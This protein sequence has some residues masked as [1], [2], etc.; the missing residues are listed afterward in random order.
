[1]ALGQMPFALPFVTLAALVAVFG[2]VA[3]GH[4]GFW[5]GWALG[6][7][8]FALTL[9]WIVEPFLVQPEIHGWMAPFALLLSAGGWA[10]YWGVAFW[11][12][13]RLGLGLLGLVALW[14]AGEV[15]RSH[16]FTGFPWALIGHVWIGTPLAQ[17]AAVIGPHGLTLLTLAFAALVARVG[18][19]PLLV[20]PAAA[21]A[22]AWV[23]LDPGPAE[24]PDRTAPV[25]RVVQPN[26]PQREKWDPARQPEHIERLLRLTAGEDR[27]D[28]VVWPETVLP[29]LIED[30]GPTLAAAAGLTGGAP[31]ALGAARLEQGAERDRYFNG[32]ALTD[33]AGGV[34]DFYDKAH[35]VPFG[36]FLP[37]NGL[38]ARLGLR[39]LAARGD[40]FSAGTGPALIE[41]PGI[42]LVRPLICYEGIFAEEMGTPERPRLLLL[43]TNDSW[44]GG[45]AGPEQHLAQARLRAIEQGLPMVRSAV[46]G[47][48]AVIDAKGRVLASVPLNEA[49]VLE[50]P[51]P[52]ALPVTV[53]A[54][55]GDAPVHLVLALLVLGAIWQRRKVRGVDPGGRAP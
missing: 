37:F 39:G 27:V 17:A 25:L 38:M 21:L 12:T 10:L 48:S 35:L 47:I 50:A 45:G 46:T 30:A 13:R 32:L 2:L 16:L 53:Y 29:F 42:G 31:I 22:L 26:I 14:T 6:A 36:E 8:Y 49:G 7:G 41:V 55:L 34:V 5:T 40:G 23:A 3:H 44:F 28:L 19:R 52:A 54:A 20:L 18:L 11:A 4:G 1:M 51:L 24:A 33:G 9:R 15:L 43:I